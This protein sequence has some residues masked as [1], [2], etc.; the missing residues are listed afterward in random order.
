MYKKQF[1]YGATAD[2]A[3]KAR[4]DYKM[5]EALG[6]TI[7]RRLLTEFAR[8]WLPIAKASVQ[9]NTYAQYAVLIEK[10][11]MHLG[12][13]EMDDIYPLDIKEV[14]NAEFLGKSDSYVKKAK[15]LYVSLFDAAIAEQLCR[16]NPARQTKAHHGTYK[17]HR[18]ITPQEREWIETLCTDHKIHP[19]VITMLYSGMRPQE[20]KALDIDKSVDFDKGEIYV[21]DFVHV[22]DTNHYKITDKGKTEH[23]TRTVP[24]FPPVKKVLLGKHGMLITNADGSPLTIQGFKRLWESYVTCMEQAINGCSKRWYGKRKEDKGKKLPDWKHFTVKPYSCRKSFIVWGR[25]LGTELRT[26]I[27]WCGH[28]DAKMILNIYDEVTSERSHSEAEK[29]I[30][31]AFGS[32]NANKKNKR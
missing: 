31:K 11:V 29:L 5:Q 32:K 16:N 30:K 20:A 6:L 12:N 13:K 17:G 9:D 4:E 1:F 18:I 23:A 7:N 19:F 15:N 24:L 27:E 28:T 14:F 8:K 22:A 26:M 2:E 25:D 3:L 10:L 21:Q